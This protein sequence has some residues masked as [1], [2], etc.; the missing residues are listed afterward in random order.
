MS[1]NGGHGIVGTSNPRSFSRMLTVGGEEA[2][3]TGNVC[4]TCSMWFTRLEGAN[5]RISVSG[6]RAAN[7]LR[8]GVASTDD[9]VVDRAAAL[10][11]DGDYDVLLLDLIPTEVTPG[12]PIDY[13]HAEE[14][15]LWGIDAFWGLP[16][17]PRTVY[18][19]TG[20][21][22]LQRSR[23]HGDMTRYAETCLY[24]FVVPHYPTTWLDPETV[25]GY[26]RRLHAAEAP[27]ALSFSILDVKQPADWEGDPQV[28][29]HATLTHFLLDG[30]HKMQAAARDG[31]P[32]S[33]LAFLGRDGIAQEEDYA[34][35]I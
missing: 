34:S 32:I 9:P 23:L 31:R 13:F 8:R 16:H 5:R 35:T 17:Y 10:L 1:V 29:K 11:T 7:D 24:E 30:H 33:L 20:V 6:E 12:D 2:F 18:Y 22:T 15:A 4:E 14:P 25:D 26:S 28:T 21:A 3:E 27:T 19:R